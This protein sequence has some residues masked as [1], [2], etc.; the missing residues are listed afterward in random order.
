MLALSYSSE[1]F[2]EQTL[3]S[4]TAQIWA[5]PFLVWLVVANVA[6]A[7][8]WIVWAVIT[9]LLSYPSRESSHDPFSLIRIHRADGNHSAS[10]PSRL[11]LAQFQH[12]AVPNRL[13]RLL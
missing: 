2:K 8:K 13:C 7:N 9:L 11:E 3:H 4:M 10:H 12:C 1:I 5:I 6:K